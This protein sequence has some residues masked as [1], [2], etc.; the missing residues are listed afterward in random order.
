MLLVGL[1]TVLLGLGK[2]GRQLASLHNGY[3]ELPHAEKEW[4]NVSLGPRT[5][6]VR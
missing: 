1:G 4:V 5:R 2:L 3:R 6:D